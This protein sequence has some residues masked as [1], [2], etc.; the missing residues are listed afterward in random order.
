MAPTLGKGPHRGCAGNEWGI[1]RTYDVLSRRFE[2]SA[3]AAVATEARPIIRRSD[4]NR[5]SEVGS[6]RGLVITVKAAYQATTSPSK[7]GLC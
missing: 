4:S 3:T 5:R 2:Q 1:G 7:V 6:S